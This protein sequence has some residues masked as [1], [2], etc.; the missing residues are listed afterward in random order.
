[1]HELRCLPESSLQLFEREWPP[2]QDN[3]LVASTIDDG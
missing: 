3:E 1:M 2:A